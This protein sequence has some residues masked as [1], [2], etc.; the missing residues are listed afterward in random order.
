MGTGDPGPNS[1][2]PKSLGIL[3]WATPP[4][5]PTTLQLE[6]VRI[7]TRGFSVYGLLR[8]CGH[9]ITAI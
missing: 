3:E 1:L 8:A 7:Y 5:P 9:F 4:P 2:P 6:R